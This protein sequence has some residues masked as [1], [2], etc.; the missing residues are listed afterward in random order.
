MAIEAN[1]IPHIRGCMR[2]LLIQ[3][4]QFPASDTL[5]KHNGLIILR[6]MPATLANHVFSMT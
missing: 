4:N 1:A 6:L 5:F 2:L 3:A